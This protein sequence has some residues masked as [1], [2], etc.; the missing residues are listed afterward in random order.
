M[1]Q[2]AGQ[3]KS[4]VAITGKRKSKSGD[5]VLI[6]FLGKVDNVAFEGGAGEDHQLELGSNSFIPGFEDQL[7]GTKAGDDVDVTVTFPENYGANELAGKEAVFAVKIK[8]IQ[9]AGEVEINDDF[10]VK[11]GLDN[12]EALRKAVSDRMSEEYNQHSRQAMKRNLL[13]A[14]AENHDFEVPPGMQAEEFKSIWEQFENELKNTEGSIEDTG[15]SEEELRDE[16][17]AIAE[18]RVR[19]GLLLAEVGRLNNYRSVQ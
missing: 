10:A 17:T 4:F 13:D 11:L 15:Q 1:Q 16:Y 2:I 3:Q 7:I 12:L 19:L 6:D 5:A 8:E 18:R 14:L 9:E